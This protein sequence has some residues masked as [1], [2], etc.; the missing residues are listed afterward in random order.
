MDLVQSREN[1]AVE[2]HF[3]IYQIILSGLSWRKFGPV[4]LNY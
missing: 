3:L 4:W 2:G 1:V